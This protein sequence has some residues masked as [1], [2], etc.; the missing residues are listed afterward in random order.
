VRR[1]FPR[2]DT[3]AAGCDFYL[4]QQQPCAFVARLT[5]DAAVSTVG[6]SRQN[7]A[8]GCLP[9]EESPAARWESGGGLRENAVT[10]DT[11]TT[12][13]GSIMP[14]PYP[15]TPEQ[16]ATLAELRKAFAEIRRA[17]QRMDQLAQRA[18]DLRTPWHEIATAIE[19][20]TDIV[21][22]RY[23]QRRPR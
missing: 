7:H 18:V 1:C 8:E 5:L 11:R 17:H 22:T 3:S 2:S 14:A 10:T 15:L 13:R 9:L 19:A 16:K 4:C 20:T 12:K 23:G 6:R 21:R